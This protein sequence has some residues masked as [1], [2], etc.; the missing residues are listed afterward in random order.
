[1]QRKKYRQLCIQLWHK[2]GRR[3][4]YA[5][6]TIRLTLATVTAF[7]TAL[8]FQ[9]VHRNFNACFVHGHIIPQAMTHRYCH[10]G[11][12]NIAI[13]ALAGETTN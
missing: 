3:E 2:V 6:N 7:T 5:V 9:A 8:A 4:L 12:S 1:M 13:N 10:E 11:C